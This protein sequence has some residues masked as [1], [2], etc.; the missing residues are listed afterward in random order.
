MRWRTA[1]G[2]G[3]A[4]TFLVGFWLSWLAEPLSS[5]V[6]FFQTG[7]S[8]TLPD[9]FSATL[10]YDGWA[11]GGAASVLAGF[12]A[13]VVS[14]WTLVLLLGRHDDDGRWRA[15]AWLVLSFLGFAALVSAR[16]FARREASVV[17][18][19]LAYGAGVA[20]IGV[21]LLL[22]AGLASWRYPR[23]M[24]VREL[25]VALL[26]LGFLAS[27]VLPWE[28]AGSVTVALGVETEPLVA[29]GVLAVVRLVPGPKLSA[30]ERLA[31]AVGTALLVGAAITSRPFT[32]VPGDGAWLG[33]ATSLALLAEAL[34]DLLPSRRLERPTWSEAATTASVA[35]LAIGLLLPWRQTCFPSS[36][37]LGAYSGR[38]VSTFPGSATFSC[39]ALLLGVVLLSEE[40]RRRLGARTGELV[41]ALCLLVTTLGFQIVSQPEPGAILAFAGTAGLA[42][43]VGVAAVTAARRLR[44]RRPETALP[45]LLCAVCVAVALVPEWGVLP[46]AVADRLAFASVSWVA[47]AAT[48]VA[49]QLGAVWIRLAG[50][51][52][53]GR[54]VILLPILLTGI[55]AYVAAGAGTDEVTWGHGV[56]VAAAILLVWLGRVVLAGRLTSIRVPEILRIDRI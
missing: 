11:A 37:E 50:S 55:V 23:G 4:L 19:H 24:H 20:A 27:L 18:V 17:D 41:V 40:W 22:V 31:L 12:V 13:L 21:I 15:A 46:Q 5:P 43:A 35:L 3:G 38:C 9:L 16:E 28:R 51:A 2:F 10:S 36:K 39:A 30:R 56:F 6:P 49:I 8:V 14:G 42:L 29:A 52:T 34:L 26:T 54:E 25:L 48:V 53:P 44:G 32:T 33:L 1:L 47:V 45:A 7:A